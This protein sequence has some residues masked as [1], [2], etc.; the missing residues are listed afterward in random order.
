MATPQLQQQQQDSSSSS[1]SGGGFVEG[2]LVDGGL[3]L[4]AASSAF[5][6]DFTDPSTGIAHAKICFRHRGGPPRCARAILEGCY[7]AGRRRQPVRRDDPQRVPLSVQAEKEWAE[8]LAEKVLAHPKRRI[9]MPKVRGSQDPSSGRH[10]AWTTEQMVALAELLGGGTVRVLVAQAAGLDD[11]DVILIAS[12]LARPECGLVTLILSGNAR[13]TA[14][15]VA[16]LACALRHRGDAGAAR[17][18]SSSL[19]L[20][21]LDL[22]ETS[23]GKPW[24]IRV[25][26]PG[27]GRLCRSAVED[28]WVRVTGRPSGVATLVGALLESEAGQRLQVLRIGGPAQPHASQRGSQVSVG[29]ATLLLMALRSGG[30]GHGSLGCV[31]L[32]G[33]A[34]T[35]EH[36]AWCH[37]VCGLDQPASGPPPPPLPPPPPPPPPPPQHPRD[38]SGRGGGGGA[39]VFH[40]RGGCR[41]AVPAPEPAR[42]PSRTTPSRTT[43][44]SEILGLNHTEPDS[45]PEPEPQPEPQPEPEPQPQPQPQP[46]PEKTASS[47]NCFARR[48]GFPVEA[49]PLSP[50]ELPSASVRGSWADRLAQESECAQRRSN[51]RR[52]EQVGAAGDDR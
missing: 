12:A 25:R 24:P 37:H 17:G 39:E 15:G 18:G 49:F 11:M 27:Q 43:E 44:F 48:L 21:V 40:D 50:P 42:A 13:V 32:S 46:Q 14:I 34:V 1:R 6:D 30:W 28:E 20:H 31:R 23:P 52:A 33:D 26:A 5:L 22:Q 7:N 29:E 51:L 41:V 2:G 47:S 45:D 38:S 16:A 3:A 36:H 35:D 4:A 19:H 8:G 9:V 10:A